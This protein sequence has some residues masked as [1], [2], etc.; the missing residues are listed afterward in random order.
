MCSYVC[1]RG[2]IYLVFLLHEA[3][4]F[5]FSK[6]ERHDWDCIFYESVKVGY[7]HVEQDIKPDRETLN[8]VY[9]TQSK[10]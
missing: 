4:S 6:I 10:T 3:F 7:S 8:N 5:C 2:I 9:F 1:L